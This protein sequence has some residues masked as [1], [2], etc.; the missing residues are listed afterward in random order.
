MDS[1]HHKYYRNVFKSSDFIDWLI[2]RHLVKNRK[3]GEELGRMLVD[4]RIIHHVSHK[5][6]FYDGH[7]FYKFNQ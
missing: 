6:N 4:G 1:F 2:R 5:R 7:H 3:Q